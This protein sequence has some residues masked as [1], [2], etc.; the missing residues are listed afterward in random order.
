MP[1]YLLA[2]HGGGMPESEAEQARVMAA[3]GEWYQRLGE[4][5]VDPGNPIGRTMTI[6]SDGSVSEGGG[7]NPVSGYTVIKA[8]DMDTAVDL[9]KGCPLLASGG[10][11]EVGE[12]ISMA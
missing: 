12:T 2:Y 11:I 6:E 10:I 5:V 9:A 7:P 8:G 1:N 3:W 4:S